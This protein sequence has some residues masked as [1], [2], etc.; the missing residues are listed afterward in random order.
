MERVERGESPLVKVK[1]MAEKRDMDS[2][3]S[4]ERPTSV[5]K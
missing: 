3:T 2:M 1:T 4:D 5:R